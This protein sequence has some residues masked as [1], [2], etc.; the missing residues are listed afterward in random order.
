MT[1]EEERQD[2][3]EHFETIIALTIAIV[4]LIGAFLGGWSALTESEASGAQFNGVIAAVNREKAQVTSHTWMFQDL[5]AYTK[6]QRL[7]TLADVTTADAVAA[8]G[9]GDVAQAQ[10]LRQQAL[11][12]RTAA[13]AAGTFFASEYV[14]PDSSF[15]EELYLE[16]QMRFE[17]RNRDVDPEDDYQEAVDLLE[18]SFVLVVVIRGLAVAIT[19]M[20]IAHITHSKLRYA[21]FAGGVAVF[22]GFMAYMAYAMK[23]IG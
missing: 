8:Q 22:L 14:L 19:L 9:V 12:Y 10:S 13:N 4:S 11:A 5:R 21:W 2:T 20:I 16:H 15:D 6:Y 17:V 3:S 23:W 7:S 18:D 1:E